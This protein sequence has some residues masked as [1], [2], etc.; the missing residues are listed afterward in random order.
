MG[1]APKQ[2]QK[3]M[4]RQALGPVLHYELT[5][6]LSAR[7]LVLVLICATTI[8]GVMLWDQWKLREIERLAVANCDAVL[9]LVRQRCER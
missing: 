8:A 6:R 9:A 1:L 2:P 4:S 5:R 3:K 7:E